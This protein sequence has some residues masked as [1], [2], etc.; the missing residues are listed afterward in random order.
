MVL[1]NMAL[2][3]Q[4]QNY[5][6]VQAEVIAMRTQADAAHYVLT[7]GTADVQPPCRPSERTGPQTL[8]AQGRGNL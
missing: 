1:A 6:V 4:Q 3:F 8:A 2:R 5:D 7:G